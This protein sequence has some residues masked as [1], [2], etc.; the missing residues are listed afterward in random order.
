MTRGLIGKDLVVET[1]KP[2]N[3]GQTGSRLIQIK[4]QSTQNRRFHPK[5][6]EN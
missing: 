5:V 6:H 1:S 2:K 4:D 3:R